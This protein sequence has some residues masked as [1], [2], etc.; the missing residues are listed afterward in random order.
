MDYLLPADLI[1]RVR[2]E[3]AKDY[4]LPELNRLYVT[5][6]IERS[7]AKTALSE[8]RGRFLYPKDKDY[9]DLDRKTL[10][11]ANTTLQE[12]NYSYLLTL[13]TAL[14]NAIAIGLA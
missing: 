10:L 14:A 2:E 5:I 11:G 4:D 6:G 8:A 12:A 9:T 1:A 3:L 7:K 13:E